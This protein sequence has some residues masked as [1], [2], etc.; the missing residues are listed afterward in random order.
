M[1]TGII[2]GIRILL[3]VAARHSNNTLSIALPPR[4]LLGTVLWISSAHFDVYPIEIMSI[5]I[6][7]RAS[8]PRRYDEGLSS[9]VSP[10]NTRT[11]SK[12]IGYVRR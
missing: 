12:Q 9:R 11:G 4:D 5:S 7:N 3:L 2:I 8:M 6:L 1:A 10:P